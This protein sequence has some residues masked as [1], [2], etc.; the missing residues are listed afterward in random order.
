MTAAELSHLWQV[1]L[2]S[3]AEKLALVPDDQIGLD[4]PL[5]SGT[6]DGPQGPLTEQALTPR[7][8][9]THLVVISYE[10]PKV[11]IEGGGFEIVKAATGALAG[12]APSALLTALQERAPKTLAM[13]EALDEAA[14]AETKATPLITGTLAEIILLTLLHVA[15]HKGQL[16]IELRRMGL[17]PGRFI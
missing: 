8:L 10:V 14:L 13:I 1:S 17:R 9:M 16:M 6:F 5:W 15:H 3:L 12:A 4:E 7:Q 2:A 11:F